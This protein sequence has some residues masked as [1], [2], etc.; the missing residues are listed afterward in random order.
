MQN[1]RTEFELQSQLYEAQL[2]KAKIERAEMTAE[3]TREKLELHKQLLES[4]EENETL[5]VETTE[6]R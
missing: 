4:K 1:A 3:F 2:A 6:F 5:L